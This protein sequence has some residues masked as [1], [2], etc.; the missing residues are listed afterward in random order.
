VNL[1]QA[2]NFSNTVLLSSAIDGFRIEEPFGGVSGNE[3]FRI[4]NGVTAGATAYFMVTPTGI[5]TSGLVEGKRLDLNGTPYNGSEF[6]L[7]RCGSGA[8]A[9]GNYGVTMVSGDDSHGTFTVVIGVTGYTNNPRII[10][11]FKDGIRANAPFVM[12]TLI[13]PMV[14]TNA[15]LMSFTSSVVQFTVSPTNIEWLLACTPSA[16]NYFTIQYVALG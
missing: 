6:T 4:D 11:N 7:A 15:A 3:L 8:S 12:A 14:P 5:L 2:Y 16:R 13:H 1:Q 9:A 10:M